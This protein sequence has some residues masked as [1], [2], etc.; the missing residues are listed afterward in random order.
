LFVGLKVERKGILDLMESWKLFYKNMPD[1]YLLMVGDE[2]SS[3]SDPDYNKHWEGIKKEI[4]NPE[5]RIINRPNH[6]AIEEYFY[7][8][9]IFIFL[10][11][12]EGMP[13]VVLEAMSAGLPMIITEFE[14][15]SDDYGED[16]KGIL[17]GK[18]RCKSNSRIAKQI[19]Q[20]SKSISNHQ[21]KF[22]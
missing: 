21:I 1:H 6:P 11:K 22:H 16:G 14:G 19:M 17:I 7:S 13:N 3:A 4:E 15:F 9:D 2:K 5:L 12:K 20:R 8:S 10:S 18:S